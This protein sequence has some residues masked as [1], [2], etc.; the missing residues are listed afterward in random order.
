MGF[1]TSSIIV[2][3]WIISIVWRWD[4]AVSHIRFVVTFYKCLGWI[5]KK[6]LEFGFFALSCLVCHELLLYLIH[7]KQEEQ[8]SR[9]RVVHKQNFAEKL[10][11]TEP[12]DM[13]EAKLR[14]ELASHW[15]NTQAIWDELSG[16]EWARSPAAYI[17]DLLLRQMFGGNS[18]C[19]IF[20]WVGA[21]SVVSRSLNGDLY[22][23]VHL[24]LLQSETEL[25]RAF[26][27]PNIFYRLLSSFLSLLIDSLQTYHMMLENAAYANHDVLPA[28]FPPLQI[29]FA[30]HRNRSFDPKFIPGFFSLANLRDRQSAIEQQ[31]RTHG[32][33]HPAL[34][35]EE[36]VSVYLR[37]VPLPAVFHLAGAAALPVAASER[38]RR[39]AAARHRL[40]RGE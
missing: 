35:D 3:V 22:R 24:L 31:Y 19:F 17:N 14:S 10:T 20:S 9:V 21:H 1:L 34:R 2:S 32:C 29:F 8:Q 38:V 25:I 26:M 7:S 5:I 16:D 37:Y 33:L 4:A 11:S 18:F 40:R 30:K 13:V 27:R 6:L 28:P 15:E 12:A 36:L 23:N 39:H